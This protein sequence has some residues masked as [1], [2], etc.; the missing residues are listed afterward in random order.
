MPAFSA[1][2]I[3]RLR[4]ETGA[5]MMDAKKALEYAEGDFEKARR[6]LREQGL[7]S[8]AKRSDRDNPEGAVAISSNSDAAAMV[9]LKCE[10]DFVA[11]SEEFLNLLDEIASTVLIKGLQAASSFTDEIDSL[12]IKLKENIE[13]AGV[14]RFEASNSTIGTYLHIQNGRGVNG[15]LVELQNADQQKAHD[16][17][18]HIAFGRPRYLD[19]SDVPSEEVEKEREI[20]QATLRNEGKPEAAIPKALEGRL[21][22]FYQERCL[23]DQPY[24][25]D[26]KITVREFLEDSKVIAFSQFI[27]GS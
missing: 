9:M 18:V 10:T 26:E 13:L 22:R 21:N 23:L 25:K 20:I 11:K 27:V 6:W 3:Q 16:L 7:A 14:Q 17:A 4:Q 1:K 24:V 15:V 19:R 12:K 8:A 5:G 2:D